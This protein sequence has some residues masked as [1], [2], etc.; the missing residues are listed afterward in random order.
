MGMI[1]ESPYFILP[2]AVILLFAIGSFIWDM[3]KEVRHKF[4]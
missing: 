3:I 1:I 4:A 2:F